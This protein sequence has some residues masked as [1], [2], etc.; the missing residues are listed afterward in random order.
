[1]CGIA[2]FTGRYDDAAG[3]LSRMLDSIAY[4][5]PDMRGER[6]EPRMA[7]GWLRLA[8][9]AP[10]GGYQPRHDEASGDSLIFNGEIY[11]Y[12]NVARQLQAEGIH[13]ADT[14]D[15]E[16]LFQAIRHWGLDA[17]LDRLDGMF[18]FAYRD[19][20][21]G[22]ITLVRD[23]FGE[24]PLYYAERQGQLIF[25]SEIKALLEHPALD[26]V[27]PDIAGLHDFLH[28]EYVPGIET[29][30]LGIRRL[31]PGHMLRWDAEDGLD[32]LDAQECY[33]HPSRYPVASDN[34]PTY[35]D[36]VAAIGQSLERSV[37]ER[38]VADVPLGLFLSGGLDSGLIAA[39]AKRHKP[40]I[41]A[42]T[43]RMP[44]GS[45][46]ETPYTVRVTEHLGLDHKVI[47]LSDDDVERVFLKATGMLDEPMADASLIPTYLVCEA[48]RQHVTVAI[49]GDGADEL[50]AGYAPMRLLKYAGMIGAVPSCAGRAL[51]R[52]LSLAPPSGGYM[53]PGFVLQQM[54]Q[55]F[56]QPEGDQWHHFMSPFPPE[57]LARLIPDA[58]ALHTRTLD[59]A[60]G[61]DLI[62]DVSRQF[63]EHYMTGHI[64]TKTD[65][66][67]MY[68][69]LELRAPFLD[70]KLAEAALAL[71]SAYKYA[72]GKGKRL[73]RS[74]AEGMLPK[75]IIRRPKHGFAPPLSDLL[76]GPLR[77]AIG[78][79]LNQRD[80]V[81]DGWLN[82]DYVMTL[83]DQH[84]KG[85]ADHRKRLYAL[86]ILKRV[87]VRA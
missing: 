83:W 62:D 25:A 71:P 49:G 27:G 19:G 36:A 63:L 16:V 77:T 67:S 82:H 39:Y 79:V 61:V 31:A 56:G 68:N 15:T 46:D 9:I 60:D 17:A 73:L 11:D 87:Y 65:R 13:L 54:S 80:H 20:E 28:F 18:A 2:G 47:D 34:A 64:L 8:I 21:D 75:E 38:L 72:G 24:K 12:Q 14:S 84:L 29:G 55:G 57:M 59:A 58:D 53:G 3:I 50:F 7:F 35:E 42:Y 33:W 23:R 69:S 44:S 40:D 10:E 41:T 81:L 86:Y 70:R 48:A 32:D 4:R 1:M 30:W 78:D 52:L 85:R 22:S 51:R 43:I 76:R 26:A 66:A 74:L 45:Y 6:V 5:G 37:A